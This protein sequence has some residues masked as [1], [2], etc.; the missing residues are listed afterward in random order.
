MPR[1]NPAQV[2]RGLVSQ[3]QIL[4]LAW[5]S[6][7]TSTVMRFIIQHVSSTLTITGLLK[8][9]Y[10]GLWQLVSSPDPTYERE[11]LVTSGWDSGFI[12]IDYFL[13][14]NIPPPITLQKIQSVVQ[15]LKFLASSARWHSTFLA[16]KLVNYTYSKLIKPKELARCHLGSGDETSDN[17]PSLHERVRSAWWNGKWE[18]PRMRILGYH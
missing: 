9:K 18:R 16:R 2:K 10:S 11:G 15:H 12:N 14:R 4:V 1:P 13:E 6:Q 3:V 5:N 17:R 7:S 8:P